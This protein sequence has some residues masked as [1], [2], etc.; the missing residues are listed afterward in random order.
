[1]EIRVNTNISLNQ[2]M[3]LYKC[4]MF[5]ITVSTV[6]LVDN[7]VILIQDNDVLRFPSGMVRASQ[8][9]IQFASLRTVKDQIGIKLVKD[10]LMPIDFRSDPSR[11]KDGNLVDIGFICITNDLDPDK[12]ISEKDNLVWKEVDFENK[13]IIDN[14]KMYMDHDILLERALEV[15]CMIKE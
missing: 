7:G 2:P 13:K 3:Y 9:T 14:C 15:A 8:E 12:I 1:M 4:P 5:A 6:L 11:S 10:A